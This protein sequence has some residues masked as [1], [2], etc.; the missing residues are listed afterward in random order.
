MVNLPKFI[1]EKSKVSN[2]INSKVITKPV[3][4]GSGITLNPYAD[5]NNKIRDPMLIEEKITAGYCTNDW[6]PIFF[7]DNRF[8]EQQALNSR[9]VLQTPSFDDEFM[10]SMIYD[11]LHNHKRLIPNMGDVRIEELLED[12]ELLKK[13]KLKYPDLKEHQA[14]YLYRSNARPSVKRTLY[15][16][17]L[18]LNSEGIDEFT[19]LTDSQC[20]QWTL[21]SSFLKME[22]LLYRTPCGIKNKAP[23]FISGA[24]A[25]FICIVG[26]WMMACQDRFKKSWGLNHFI[27]FTS[28]KSNE[29]IGECISNDDY[30]HHFFEDDIGTFDSSVSMP[31]LWLEYELFRRWGAPRA[32]LR[33]IKANMKTRGRTKHGFRYKVWATRK[34]GDPY[35]S[36]G[37][38]L[39]NGLMHYYIAKVDTFKNKLVPHVRCWRDKN[40]KFH[41]EELKLNT[42]RKRIDVEQTKYIMKILKMLVQGDDNV[43]RSKKKID[44]V[45]Y[46]SKFGFNSEA[47]NHTSIYD[48]QFCSSRFYPTEDGV[49]MGPCPGKVISKFGYYV[50]K[51]EH[52]SVEQLLRGSAIGLYKQCYFIEP[53]R[54]LL[55]HIIEQT[56]GVNA[57]FTKNYDWALKTKNYHEPTGH[58]AA[59]LDSVYG[60]KNKYA[61]HFKNCL[62]SVKDPKHLKLPYLETMFDLDTNG[63][64]VW[65]N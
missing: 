26:P 24:E 29:E 60:W 63:P 35:T 49:V 22:N 25:E 62:P 34:S 55:D 10:V 45:P 44:W 42:K 3:K 12:K 7:A 32:V 39:L 8:N 13:A 51:P 30:G 31:L 19:P 38:S 57:Y 58:T 52:V 4:P 47:I 41:Y 64:K 11:V 18:R 1:F 20:K 5:K 15:K 50:E 36:L 56:E 14:V 2:T 28:G 48:A 65:F 21:R 43:G 59:I 61:E 27:T 54:V 37:N 6:A 9:V 16:T 33:L 17:F 46:M 53:I 23:R 40:K